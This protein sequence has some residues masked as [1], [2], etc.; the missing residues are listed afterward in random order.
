MTN[1]DKVWK[2]TI[3]QKK[4]KVKSKMVFEKIKLYKIMM[5]YSKI[6]LPEIGILKK[7]GVGMAEQKDQ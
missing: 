3:K 1:S 7:W 2:L 5:K 6:I 4:F